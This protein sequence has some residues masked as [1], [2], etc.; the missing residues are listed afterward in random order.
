MTEGGRQ[1]ERARDLEREMRQTERGRE[2]EV[3]KRERKMRQ[4]ERERE[5]E[6]MT[7]LRER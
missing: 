2:N 6:R 7:W 3:I 1:K 4:T 5:K